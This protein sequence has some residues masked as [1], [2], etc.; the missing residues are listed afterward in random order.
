MLVEKQNIRHGVRPSMLLLREEGVLRFMVTIVKEFKLDP[1]FLENYR[2]RQ[3]KWGPVGYITYKRTYARNVEGENRSEEWWETLRRVVE[4]CYTIQLNHC[5]QLK[6][7]WSSRKAQTSAQEMYKLMWDF[8]FLPPGRGLWTMGTSYIFQRGS[9]PLNNCA[10]VSTEEI[11]TNFADP[12]CFLMDM[13][14]LGVGVS[15]DCKGAGKTTIREPIRS[16]EVHMVEDSKEGWVEC[17]KTVLEAYI[18]Y[19][20]IPEFDMSQIRPEGSPIKTFGGIAPGPKPLKRCVSEIQTVLNPMIGKKIDS[21]TI[22]DLFNIVGKCVVSGGVRRTAEMALGEWDD[23]E[24]LRLKDPKANGKYL[25]GWRWA[26]NNSVLVKVGADYEKL[27]LQTSQNG[28]PGYFWL[29]NARFFGR[30]K[31]GPNRLDFK[32]LGC[33]PCAEQTLE[34]FELCCLVETYPEYHDTLEEYKRTCKFA[35]L[36]A[37][38]VTLIPTHNERTNQIMLRNRR[39]GLSMSGIT[40]SFEKFG[41]REF[42]NWC[43]QAYEY[44]KELDQIYSD[45]LCVPSSKKR[46]SV[47][48]SGTISLLPGVVPGIHYP[49]S[50]FYY[51]TIRLEKTHPLLPLLEEAGHRCEPS[52][53]EDNTIVV[54]FPIKEL[55]KRS[56]NEVSV[57]EQ[58]ENLAQM[59]Y[60]WSDNQ[61]SATV[62]F[63]PEEAKDLPII[64]QLYEHRLKS[65]SFLPLRDHKYVQAPYQTI[66][67]EEYEEAIKQLKPLD[68]SSISNISN[69]ADAPEKGCESG[70]CAML[71]LND[72][73]CDTCKVKCGGLRK[74]KHALS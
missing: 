63:R 20:R 52:V 48:P 16:S 22:V 60:W 46:T 69:T 72:G 68:Y 44:I 66:T 5:L 56:K 23:E 57:W 54:Y 31:D 7:P 6:L 12:F 70:S 27:A 35:Y 36:Y 49:H 8:K 64:L 2:D 33:N 26:S 37:K 17:I 50:Q 34:S 71:C 47:K 4:G 43:D 11:G 18:G 1:K 65:I 41:R 73:E 53:A 38:T 14:M 10:F 42:F 28:E 13:S 45:W 30:M 19:G 55:C 15:F 21:T 62:T 29:D 24:Y 25:K 61:V 9:A 40:T 58:V 74:K 39:I 32:A 51:R 67:E 59:Q 3:P